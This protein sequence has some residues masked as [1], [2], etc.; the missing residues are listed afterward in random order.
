MVGE[1]QRVNAW[2]KREIERRMAAEKDLQAAKEQAE[3]GQP[4]QERVPCQ[5]EPRDQTPMNGILA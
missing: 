1:Q 4:G 5:H 2:L 3:C